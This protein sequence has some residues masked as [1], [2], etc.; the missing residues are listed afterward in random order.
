MCFEMKVAPVAGHDLGQI[1]NRH[2]HL[3]CRF[4]GPAIDGGAGGDTDAH[5]PALSRDLEIAASLTSMATW[6][7]SGA[8]IGALL[9][10]GG[11]ILLN[12]LPLS[13]THRVS[14]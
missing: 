4:V 2:H 11:Y 12:Y 3:P 9:M 7:G 5:R 10:V 8:D 6:T 14:K 13:T 1:V